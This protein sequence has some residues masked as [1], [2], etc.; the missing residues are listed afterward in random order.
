MNVLAKKK[1]EDLNNNEIKSLDVKAQYLKV[2]ISHELIYKVT[3][4]IMISQL[5]VCA[6]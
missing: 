5:F 4:I 1:K 3:P 6:H 2:L